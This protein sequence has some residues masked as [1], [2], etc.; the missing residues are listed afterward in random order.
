L[1]NRSPIVEDPD[2]SLNEIVR[3]SQNLPS[4]PNVALAA[5]R[6]ATD[7]Q[8]S[9]QTM[10]RILIQ[11]QA[12]V[13]R[14]LKL[15]NSAYFGFHREVSDVS[16]A[17]VMLGM[18]T[19]RNLALCAST[20]PWLSRALS[21]YGLGP[22]E[23]WA[24]SLAV[25]VGS[26]VVA[27]RS[28][29]ANPDTAFTAGILHDLGKTAVSSWIEGKV[30]AMARLADLQKGSFIDVERRV[31]GFDHQ[32]V[33]AH[34]AKSWN[35]PKPLISAMQH[36]HRPFHCEDSTE[37]VCCVHVGD[38]LSRAMCIGVGGDSGS[39]QFKEECIPTLNISYRDMDS[40]ADET[41]NRFEKQ[42]KIFKSLS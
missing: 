40:I 39:Y 16:E 35:L 23:L 33:G 10:A 8:A 9:A 26:Q 29:L 14:V 21:G 42:E 11:D 2:L 32:D 12:L 7:P 28:R 24:H 25:A 36:H 3:R 15:A 37:I 34:M 6:H 13:V 17:V 19:I 30:T 27:E 1:Q 22:Q 20:H 4:A 18:R 38:Y 5:M 31:L 41:L